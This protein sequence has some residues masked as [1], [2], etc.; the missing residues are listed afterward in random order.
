[1]SFLNTILKSFLGNKNEKDLKEVKKVVAKIKAV[2]PEVGKL[3]D[4][5][6]RQKTE[7]FQN[8]IKEATSKITSQVEELKEKIK[9]SKDVDEKEALFNKI[10]ELKKEAYQI[11][12][13]VLTDILPEAFAVLKETARR[14][15]QNGE[16]RVKANDR[17]RALAATKDFVVI[18]GDEAVWLNHWDAAGTK[19]QW[20][21]V[22][23]DVQF[24]GG[25]VLHSGK[26]AE[27]A[28]GEGKTL[29]GTLPIYLNAL[30]GRGVHVVTVNDYLA[31]RDSAWMGPLYEFHGLSIDCIDNHQ[32]NS[33]ARRKAYQCNITYGTNNEF[34][35]DYLRDNMVNSP[36]EM[37]QGEL[38]YAIVDEVDSVLID[39][40]RTP[41]IISGP[42]PQGDRQEFDVLKPSVDRIVDVQKK[43]VS[44]IFHEAKKLIAQGNTKEGGFKLLQAYRGLPKNRQLIKF[45]SE[46]GNKA[47]LQKV[48]A[49]YM[50]DN[51]RE[52]PKVDKD[53]Y[54][55]IDEKNNQIDLTDKGVEYMSQG[56]S[57]P[58]FFVLQDIGTELAELEAQNLPKEEEFAKKEELFRD[59]AVKSERI[60]TLNQLLKAYTLFEKDDQYVVM[61]GEVKIVDEQTGRIMEGR[62]YSDGLHQAIEAKENV[63]IEAATQTFATITLQNYFRMYNKLAGMTGTAETEAGEFWEIY[64]L[65]VVVIPTNRPIQR[66][67]KHDLVYKTNR[68]KYNAVIEEVEKLTSAGRPVL[69]GT[70][71]VEISQLL[72]KA[73]QLRK[74]PHQV[75]N[76]K[77]H[78][79]EAE[80][81]AEAGRAGVV[82]IATNMAG[83]GTDIKLSKEVKDAG[84]LAIIGTERHDSRRVDRQLRGRA[85]RQGDPGSSQF[86]VSLEDNLMRLFG[87]ERIAKM[88]DRLGHKEG[89]VIQHS[90]ITRSIERAQKKVEENNFGIRKRLLEYDDVMNKQRDVI[91]KRRK[92]ALFGD[93]LKYD[94]ANMIFDVSHSI[95]NQTKMHGDYKDFEFEVIKYFT[96]E[97]PVSE[98][99][100]KN[101]TVKELTDI[102]FKKAQ[103]DYEMKLNLL[104]EKSF[105]IIENVYQ[106]QGNMFK[107]IQVPFSDGTKTMTIL[108]D[109]KEAYETQ[110]DSLINDFEK[111]I[112]L[113]IIDENWK[114]HLREMDDLR[115]SSQGAVYEQKDPLVIYKQES[116]HLFS[117]MVDKINKEIIS[118]LY[119]GEI[120]A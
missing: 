78:K 50:Q 79:K 5:G 65:D 39:D 25:V 36:N 60:H 103:E 8:K 73:L 72:S 67:D 4:D 32:P 100:F 85:G 108:A 119:K 112:C 115:R 107:M 120:P 61:D 40:A 34:G 17:D 74:I 18:E 97:A 23:Y 95:V 75:L 116:F 68:E 7:E 27:M 44:A 29:V 9:T 117:E 109:L 104:K 101:K 98:A 47:L 113:S 21:M 24:I 30:P 13:K 46:T 81:V 69:V 118:F 110:C 86:Y 42:V 62:R 96:M 20:D 63:K 105:P 38:N 14:W 111:N 3:S 99:D 16:I 58:N 43:T 88:M 26:I 56:N 71:S 45:L 76:A 28:T 64:K 106:N 37:V 93:H 77:L 22:H 66:N 54:F 11:E 90:M 35:F 59:F 84:G 94:I 92:N 89:E 48:E 55:V 31:R 51:N 1:M 53:L 52:M 33:D 49:Q 91:Y 10:E 82:T 83:R 12:E 80:I 114:L 6:L 57:D 87:S 70:T 19:V 41:L 2:E 102:V 15:A